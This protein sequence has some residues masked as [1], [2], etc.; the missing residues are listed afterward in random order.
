MKWLLPGQTS[1]YLGFP[2][3][4]KMS[5]KAK[6]DKAIQQIRSKLA[7]WAP[8]KLSMAAHVLVTNQVVLASIWYL[9]SCADLSKSVLQKARTLVG[10]FIWGGSPDHNARARVAQG[11]NG[12]STH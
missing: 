4:Y 11:L 9:A 8:R 3:G 5:Q 12:S 2:V 1:R 7:V 6:N 10:N